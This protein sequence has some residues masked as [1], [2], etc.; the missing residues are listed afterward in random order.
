MW[1]SAPYGLPLSYVQN[2]MPRDAFEFMRR[3]IHFCDNDE[4]KKRGQNG[5]DPLF[6][7]IFMDG[8]QDVWHAGKHICI[9]ESMIKYMGRAI[10]FVQYMKAKPIKHAAAPTQEYYFRSPYMSARTILLPRM[11]ILRQF[12]TTLSQ[13]LSSLMR[14][15][16]C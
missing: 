12:V 16:E 11:P 8:L 7:V 2:C 9:N 13:R 15:E 3:H 1:R 10:S 4:R 6:K 5:Y 14:V